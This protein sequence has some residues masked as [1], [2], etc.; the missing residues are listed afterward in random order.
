MQHDELIWEIINNGHCSFKSKVDD[1]SIFCR[2][3]YNV[4]GLCNRSS[5]PLANS[6]YATIREH[7]GRCYLYIKTAERAHTPKNLWE[8]IKLSRNYE[9][10][11]EQ[12]DTHLQYFPKFLLHKN[13]QRLTKITQY[14][15]RMR[16]LTKKVQPRLMRIHKKVE[17]R[18][19]RREQ[20]ALKAANI[21][22]SIEKELLSRLKDGTYGDIY[23][24]PEAQYNSALNE[25][26]SE[27]ENKQKGTEASDEG[28][29]ESDESD[30]EE[31]EY[32]E[33]ADIDEE[34]DSDVEE[35]ADKYRFSGIGEE[36]SDDEDGFGQN[37]L[38]FYGDDDEEDEETGNSNQNGISG[39]KRGRR[40]PASSSSAMK[41]KLK[42]KRKGTLDDDY[43]AITPA[44]PRVEIEYEREDEDAGKQKV[45]SW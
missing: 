45:A 23:N 8:K 33:D 34:E 2:N 26:S 11:L 41:K 20:K 6:R 30:A 13:K 7:E 36:D 31:I 3:P 12:V 16:K 14:L 44:K 39:S 37:D 43:K 27:Y 4:T 40:E 38:D 24:F 28:E 25:A 5:C 1:K 32:V 17:Q 10:A 9:K 21:E 15:I 42:Q 35:I 19:K 29:G 22:K 18:E